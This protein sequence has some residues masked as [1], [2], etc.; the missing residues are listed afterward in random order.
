MNLAWDCNLRLDVS[1]GDIIIFVVGDVSFGGEA[2]ITVSSD[3][4]N[5]QSMW[6]VDPNLAAKVYLETHGNFSS[7]QNGRWFGAILA[8]NNITFSGGAESGNKA[9]VIGL[10]A[11]VDGKITLSDK[12][13]NI[14]IASNFAKAHW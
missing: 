4:A 9:K 7:G 6:S 5:Y 2:A 8:K 11:T 13:T 12:F 10:L 3:G 14:L 1:G